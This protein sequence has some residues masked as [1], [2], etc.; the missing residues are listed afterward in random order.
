MGSVHRMTF[1]IKGGA[2]VVNLG[3]TVGAVEV[4]LDGLLQDE[5]AYTLGTDYRTLTFTEPLP[6]C[7]MVVK[8][9]FDNRTHLE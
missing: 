4:S 7:R 8:A 9:I 1:N 3:M 5:D 2:T 6:E